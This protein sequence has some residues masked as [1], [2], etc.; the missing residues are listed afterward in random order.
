MQYPV[1]DNNEIPHH[2]VAEIVRQYKSSF[3]FGSKNLLEDDE[4]IGQLGRATYGT[5]RV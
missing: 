5:S 3:R 4:L 1:K 2:L